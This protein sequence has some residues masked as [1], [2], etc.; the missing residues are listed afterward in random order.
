M[1][2]ESEALSA[3]IGDIYDAS[4][5]PTLWVTALERSCAFVGGGTAVLFWH[6]VA[7]ERSEVLH[8]FE[9]D[10]YYT[11]LYFEKY[12]PLNP[13]FP[14]A[15]FIEPGQVH[16]NR[17]L[18]PQDELVQTRFYREWIEP[19]GIVET[20]ATVLERGATT[21]AFLNIRFGRKEGEV[22]VDMRRRMALI[23]PHFQRAVAI[24]RLFDQS[25]A[26]E[27]Q[28]TETL[29]H[30]DAGV[31]LVG[32]TGRIA[33]ANARANTMLADGRL[34][35]R[36]SHG[37]AAADP[38][39][40]RALRDLFAAAAKGDASIG[41]H[42]VAVALSASPDDRWFAHVLPLTAGAGARTRMGDRY[43]AVAV[44][45]VRR[46][47]PSNPTRLEELVKQYGLTASEMRVLDAVL[48]VSG[49][50]AIAE[51][52]GSSPETVKTHL[53]HIFQKTGTGRQSDLV[54][55]AAGLGSGPST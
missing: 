2:S 39:A 31:F 35:R 9:E 42:G 36:R 55:L 24:G 14:A 49:I 11:Q 25:K 44:V 53:R 43:D 8:I 46:T 40:D 13:V 34:L 52:I 5:D 6:D 19:Q 12:V 26:V 50:K 47:R 38:E 18:V 30:V 54:R 32:P 20:L 4:L 51:L 48:K 27:T 10:P 28:L 15:M 3:L 1:T 21:S 17:D 37:L 7:T 33:F 29:D 23:V 22:T 45:F 41:Q 16:S